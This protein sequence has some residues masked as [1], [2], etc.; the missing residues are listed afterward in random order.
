MPSR[1]NPSTQGRGQRARGRNG[2]ASGRSARLAHNTERVPKASPAGL[3]LDIEYEDDSTAQ[4]EG[5][6]GI[7]RGKAAMRAMTTQIGSG[8]MS[9]LEDAQEKLGEAGAQVGSAARGAGATL[10]RAGR[11]VVDAAKANPVAFALL[12]MGGVGLTLLLTQTTIG[13]ASRP[14]SRSP[15]DGSDDSDG[16]AATT[17][18]RSGA[19]AQ[20]GTK[21]KSAVGEA[22]DQ[23]GALARRVQGGLS[24]LPSAAGNALQKTKQAARGQS[25]RIERLFVRNPAATTASALAIGVGIGMMIPTS[26]LEDQLMGRGRDE[27]IEKAR[28][29]A[30]TA[31]DKLEGVAEIVTSK[32]KKQQGRSRASA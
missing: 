12:G 32:P 16:G 8:V 4:A 21:L 11:A 26:R 20:A 30:H 3:E 5:E 24:E 1:T 15:R 28:G 27:L 14:S 25:E 22:A 10:G 6:G 7:A 2:S 17:R 19:A 23:A 29:Y 31:I 18:G 9:G 13:T